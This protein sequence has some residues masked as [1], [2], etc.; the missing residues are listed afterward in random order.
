MP[1]S[2]G[3]RHRATLRAPTCPVVSGLLELRRSCGVALGA[4][5]RPDV[6]RVGSRE[7]RFIDVGIVPGRGPRSRR[8]S[9]SR[10]YPPCYSASNEPDDERKP[11][12]PARM[13]L[14]IPTGLRFTRGCVRAHAIIPA[15]LACHECLAT[16]ASAAMRFGQPSPSSPEYT[17][18]PL[19]VRNG[20][21][22]LAHC[23]R[24]R[25]KITRI[26]IP[27]ILPLHM[28]SS[29]TRFARMCG[30]PA[31]SGSPPVSAPLRQL[32]CDFQ[33]SS[34]TSSESLDT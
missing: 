10:P 34:Q 7:Y 11:H 2:E 23:E 19:A 31:A 26:L 8:R 1:W 27:M 9:L 21:Q 18:N 20:C 4:H 12:P 30:T 3:V 16:A 5:P 24:R 14:L 15:Q 25:E 13:P 33:K 22:F 6:A 29:L 32:F 17:A 28:P